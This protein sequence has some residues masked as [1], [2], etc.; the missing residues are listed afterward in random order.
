MA[1]GMRRMLPLA[2]ISALPII[3]IGSDCQF[4]SLPF[5]VSIV[6]LDAFAFTRPTHSYDINGIEGSPR[7]SEE[8]QNNLVFILRRQG[9][10]WGDK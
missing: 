3:L 10:K 6:Y 9:Q 4:P 2:L 7:P 5:L 8:H 1:T